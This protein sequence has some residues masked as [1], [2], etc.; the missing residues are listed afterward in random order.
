MAAHNKPHVAVIGGGCA[1]LATATRLAQHGI[2]V[3]LYDASPQFG[4]RARKI[5]WKTETLDN[6]QHILL[7]AYS[8]TLRLLALTGV[9][10]S[11]AVMRLPLQ[12]SIP[13][14][15]GLSANNWLPA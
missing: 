3:S 8:E 10:L 4:G 13:G 1:G 6:G 15:F 12:I 11:A 9:D 14:E 5:Q 7:G 2:A